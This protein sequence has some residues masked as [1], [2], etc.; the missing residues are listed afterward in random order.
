MVAGGF[1]AGLAFVCSGVLEYELEKTY[2]MLPSKGEG[3]VNF[4]NSLP[5]NLTLVDPQGNIQILVSGDMTTI[6]DIPVQN[7]S[8]Y[9]VIITGPSICNDLLLDV[10]KTDLS[11]PVKEREVLNYFFKGA[12][13]R[14]GGHMQAPNYLIVSGSYRSH[15]S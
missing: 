13:R 12:T 3:F 9:D 7:L 8:N 6:K 10:A 14:G 4:V 15:R 11:I 5:C 2:P 1:I